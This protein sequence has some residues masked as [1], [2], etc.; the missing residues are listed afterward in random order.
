MKRIDCY[1]GYIAPFMP[2]ISSETH[3]RS[4]LDVKKS[5]DPLG[6]FGVRNGPFAMKSGEEIQR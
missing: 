3:R 2:R 6:V 5:L 4:L 1:F